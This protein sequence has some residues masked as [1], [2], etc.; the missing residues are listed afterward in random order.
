MIAWLNLSGLL[1]VVQRCKNGSRLIWVWGEANASDS[2]EAGIK[3]DKQQ[4]SRCLHLPIQPGNPTYGGSRMY[5][6]VKNDP[7]YISLQNEI[8][9]CKWKIR[10]SGVIVEVRLMQL[11]RSEFGEKWIYCFRPN[12]HIKTQFVPGYLVRIGCVWYSYLKVKYLINL[13]VLF[14]YWAM[15]QF[16]MLLKWES[17]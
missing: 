12:F 17:I 6:L 3:K 7:H 1:L 4:S 15:S 8:R 16:L 14:R 10:K 13:N 5:V 2:L 9:A 11:F